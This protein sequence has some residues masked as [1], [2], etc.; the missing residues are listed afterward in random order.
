VELMSSTPLSGP[1]PCNM[2]HIHHF[3]LWDI[4]LVWNCY[5]HKLTEL[6]PPT[7]WYRSTNRFRLHVLIP[8]FSSSAT[9]LPSFRF[10]CYCRICLGDLS[11]RLSIHPNFSSNSAYVHLFQC[12]MISFPVF[13]RYLNFK[14]GLEQLFS[15]FCN[16]YNLTH[17]MNNK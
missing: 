10:I 11:C 13:P 5:K 14:Y 6:F 16:I 1:N 2:M 12:A 8:S 4:S 15:K 7:S 3:T 9:A 17:S